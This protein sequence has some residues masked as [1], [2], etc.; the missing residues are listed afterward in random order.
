ME[1]VILHKLW[2]C[3]LVVITVGSDLCLFAPGFAFA[4]SIN[5]HWLQLVLM[6]QHHYLV[7]TSGEKKFRRPLL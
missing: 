1:R 7:S 6:L 3:M 2:A 5:Q 4:L